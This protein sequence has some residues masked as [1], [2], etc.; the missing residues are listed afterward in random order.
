M[1]L[2]LY[3]I[4][5]EAYP[6]DIEVLS[7]L[8][9]CYARHGNWEMVTEYFTRAVD[10]AQRQGEY[11]W[12]LYRDWGHMYVRYYME[13]EA[14]EKF[15]EARVRLLRETGLTDDAGILAAEGFLAERNHDLA[16]AAEKYESA[17]SFNSAHEFTITNYA[18]LLRRQGK[19][20]EAAALEQR[21]LDAGAVLGESTDSFF[22]DF[23]MVDAVPELYDD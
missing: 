1:A 19:A 22:S 13:A 2:Q 9:R 21:L 20:A 7:Y 5:F 8:G 12:Y 18:N 14:V 3:Q 10:A 23:D 6:E 17:L 15:A 16:G 11:T 4:L